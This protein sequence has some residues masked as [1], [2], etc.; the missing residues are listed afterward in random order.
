MLTQKQYKIGISFSSNYQAQYVQPFAEALL[1]LGFY[2]E[3]VFYYPWHEARVNGPEGNKTLQDIYHNR[4]KLI[5]VLLSPDYSKKVWAGHIEWPAVLDVIIHGDAD[6][7]CLL[8]VGDVDVSKIVG[9]YDS[10]AIKK[11]IDNL[12]PKDVALFVAEKYDILYPEDS[13]VSSSVDFAR[14]NKQNEF[15]NKIEKLTEKDGMMRCMHK[16]FK[17]NLDDVKIRLSDISL[18]S[19]VQSAYQKLYDEFDQRGKVSDTEEFDILMSSRPVLDMEIAH[20]THPLIPSYLHFIK[21]DR[22]YFEKKYNEAIK[23]YQHAYD[24]IQNKKQAG[25]LSDV[26][27]QTCVYLLNSI[28]WSIKEQGEEESIAKAIQV[29]EELFATYPETDKYY[30][31]WKYR[32]NYGVCL[33]RDG[34]YVKAMDQYDLALNDY[35]SAEESEKSNEYKIYITYCSVMMKYW[36]R[37]TK[38]T[39]GKWISNTRDQYSKKQS[40]LTDEIFAKIESRLNLFHSAITFYNAQN[41]LPDYYNQRSKLLTYQMIISQDKH[42]QKKIAY[43]IMQNL[44]TLEIVSRTAIGWH[45][46]KRDFYYAQFELTDDLEDKKAFLS[47]ACEENEK[48][49]NNK[50]TRELHDLL[51]S[52]KSEIF[53]LS[54]S[55]ENNYFDCGEKD[56]R[57]LN[58]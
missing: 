30:F 23:E 14:T 12:S 10:Q 32:R 16:A 45:F 40:F 52:K 31:A 26:D 51:E 7:I 39:S 50:E 18:L 49:P 8:Q 9:L 5:V 20:N 22:A 1:D 4:C 11:H 41:K 58:E 17:E 57:P 29:Y 54:G 28:A 46:V 53:T 34:Q 43:E 25:Q 42:E 44:D 6:K 55:D 3:D 2:K 38:K 47:I 13:V 35:K 33:E 36:D 24:K 48:L 27:K 19:V 56:Q 15:L 37:E 21:A